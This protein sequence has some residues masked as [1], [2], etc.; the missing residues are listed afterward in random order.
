MLG[1][2][3]FTRKNIDFDVR[4]AMN[5]LMYYDN[6]NPKLFRNPTK[7]ISSFE[8]LSQILPPLSTRMKNGVYGET[9]EDNKT[10]NNIIEIVNGKYIRGQL[11][12]GALG[13]G[14]K[15]LIQT[16]LND[17]NYKESADFIDNLQSIVTEYMKL[18][19]YSV[20][21]SD[22]IADSETNKSTTAVTLKKRCGKFN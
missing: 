8:I 7:R 15:G 10:S 21:I 17:F 3:R 2:A 20:G 13:K 11:D 12:K 1:S 18:S 22:L 4:H 6:V 16:I 14:S 5:L 9:E 19:A